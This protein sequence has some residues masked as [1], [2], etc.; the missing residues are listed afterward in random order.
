MY[1]Y[2]DTDWNNIGARIMLNKNYRL[3]GLSDNYLL[4]G[5]TIEE[6]YSLDLY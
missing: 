4:T 3:Y 6:S 1:L 2:E 5:Y